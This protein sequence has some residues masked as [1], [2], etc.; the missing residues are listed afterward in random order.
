M[1]VFMDMMKPTHEEIRRAFAAQHGPMNGGHVLYKGTPRHI[2]TVQ[3]FGDN[4][5]IDQNSGASV[6]P[7]KP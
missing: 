2:N 4:F 1:V 5:G 6:T 7:P 3:D